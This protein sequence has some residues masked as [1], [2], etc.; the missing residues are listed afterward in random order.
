[1]PA[2]SESARLSSLSA[3]PT[4]A[5]AATHRRD[6]DGLRAV[7]VLPVILFHAGVPA[8]SGGYLGVD[9]FFVISGFLITGILA[10]DLQ[11]G[12]FSLARFYERRA[13]RILPALTVVLLACLPPAIAWLSPNELRL[14]AESLLATALS[15]SNILF[16]QQLDYFGPDA[17]RLPLLHTWSLGIEEQFYLLFPLPLLFLWRRRLALPGTL[18]LLAASLAF[19]FWLFPRAPSA[20]FFLLPTRA[21]ELLAGAALALAAPRLPDRKSVV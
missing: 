5:P 21:W 15:V 17:H 2:Q 20:T 19:A 12:R 1:M 4:Y 3:R 8:L 16:W 7:A 13:R 9:I 6:I 14:F 11:A 18:A 10:R